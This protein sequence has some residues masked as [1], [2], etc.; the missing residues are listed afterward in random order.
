M[1]DSV[2]MRVVGTIRT[3]ELYAAMAKF[4]SVAPRQVARIV[5][6]IEQATD[7]DGRDIDVN[8]LAGVHFQGPPE[9]VP[10]FAAGERVQI[11][12]TTPSGMHIASIRPA[13][14]S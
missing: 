11:V 2:G 1:S 10:L 3:I 12:T 13:P 4:H 6:E 14:L 8:N 7:G 9:L 5:L